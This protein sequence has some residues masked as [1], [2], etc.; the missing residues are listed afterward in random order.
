MDTIEPRRGVVVKP[1]VRRPHPGL[2]HDAPPGLKTVFAS[3]HALARGGLAAMSRSKLR[4]AVTAALLAFTLGAG[5]TAH[6]SAADPPAP[7]QPQPPAEPVWWLLARSK[8]QAVALRADGQ[9][10]Q[11]LPVGTELATP[12][13]QPPPWGDRGVFS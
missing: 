11:E 4:A 8:D 5:L 13:G 12:E 1:R 7:A 3:V 10:R 9:A 6:R 2:Y